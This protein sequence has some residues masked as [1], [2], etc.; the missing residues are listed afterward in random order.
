VI[1]VNREAEYFSK[2]GWTANW[3]NSLSG[4]SVEP[5]SPVIPG[6]RAGFE[7]VAINRKNF[8]AEKHRTNDLPHSHPVVATKSSNQIVR[9]VDAIH[10][11]R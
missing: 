10:V 11:N 7:D 5:S 1:W 6:H 8:C 4:K 2:L 9:M 3:L